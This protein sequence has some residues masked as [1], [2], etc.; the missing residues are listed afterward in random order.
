MAE[1]GVP[2]YE[3]VGWNGIFVAKGTPPEIVAKLSA[4]LPKVLH[5]PD[6]KEQMAALGAVPGGDSCPRAFAA[7]RSTRWGKIIQEKGIKPE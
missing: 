6:V 7:G 5:L 1:A 3:M 4:E 2:G